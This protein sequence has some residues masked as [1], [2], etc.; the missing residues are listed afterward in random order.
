MGVPLKALAFAA[1]LLTC[2]CAPLTYSDEGAIDFQTYSRV[3]VSVTTTSTGS[4]AA[5]YLVRELNDSSGFATVTLDPAVPVDAVLAVTLAVSF[6]P[7]TDDQGHSIDQYAATADYALTAGGSSVDS[8]STTATDSTDID[9]AE[10]AL[11]G[12]VAHYVAPY[13]L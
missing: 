11:D 4:D 2:S 5:D 10:S 7:T 8:G 9:A 12:V 3:R 1:L 13:R 6:S